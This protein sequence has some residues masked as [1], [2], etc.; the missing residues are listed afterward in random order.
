MKSKWVSDIQ[1]LEHIHGY[2]IYEDG[3][4]ESYWKNGG[5]TGAKIF[6]EPVR[7]LKPMMN[8]KGYYRVEL[9]GKGY[10]VHRLVAMAFIP[11][12]DNK[13]Q[14]NHI[15]GIK[16][17]NSVDNLE[18][19]TNAENH[20]HKC[21]NGLNIVKRG[22]EHYAYGQYRENHH[23]NKRVGKYSLDN[24]LIEEYASTKIA[25]KDVGCHPSTI[26]KA[27]KK[28]GSTAKGFYWKYI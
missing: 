3:T 14:V 24:E 25:S 21:E 11:N 5:N 28:E 23:N 16:T 7:N 8:H 13:E 6:E 1:G 15:D 4:V 20:K 12:V 18:W 27:L 19:V 17:N 26:T 22:K 9:K 10:F 2:K